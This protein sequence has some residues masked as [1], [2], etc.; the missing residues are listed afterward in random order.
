M[1]Q[2]RTIFRLI[3]WSNLLFIIII[4]LLMEKMVAEPL[5]LRAQF[6]VQLPWWAFCLLVLAVVLI[7][8]GGYVINDYFDVRIDA[9]NRPEKQI[10]TRTVSK[11]SAMLMHQIFT[12]LGVVCGLE[13]AWICHSWSLCLIF[14]FVPGLLWFYSSSYKRQFL[15]GNLIVAFST[16][17]VPL[18][19][20]M[21]YRLN[22]AGGNWCMCA[23]ACF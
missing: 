4:M 22:G 11:Q 14:I 21:A 17:L 20:A 12:V 3:R 8:A 1:N 7:A 9:I 5:M 18:L 13:V 23:T 6:G 2:V 19:M 10:V 16:A 15:V